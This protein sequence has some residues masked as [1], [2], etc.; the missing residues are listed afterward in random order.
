MRRSGAAAAAA[1]REAARRGAEPL[2]DAGAVPRRA[3]RHG[4]VLVLL[5][6]EGLEA[7]AREAAL[8]RHVDGQRFAVE[9]ELDERGA[10]QREARERCAR[11]HFSMSDPLPS[12]Q[13]AIEGCF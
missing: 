8:D 9:L 6:H 10:R 5:G 4:D 13:S 1:L 11:L 2:H 3:A 7:A 12:N